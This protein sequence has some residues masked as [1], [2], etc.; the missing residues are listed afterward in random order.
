MK[1]RPAADTSRRCSPT[2]ARRVIAAVYL[3]GGVEAA[4]DFILGE[5]RD[6]IEHVRSPDFLRDF[7]SALQERLQ[8]DRTAAARL[9]GDGRARARPRQA[10]SRHRAGQGDVLANSEGRTKKEA[11]QSAAQQALQKID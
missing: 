2:A 8:A 10:V 9:R 6:E 11:E 3:D 4:R 7:K 5:L 1:R